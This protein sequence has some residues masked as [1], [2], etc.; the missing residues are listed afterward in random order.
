MSVITILD[1]EIE[2]DEEG[3][4]V[5]PDLWSEAIA[6]ALAKADG[7]GELTEKHWDAIR[8]IRQYWQENHMPPMV[9]SICENANL[10]LK[11]IYVLFPMGPHRGASKIAG[12]PGPD[13]CVQLGF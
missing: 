11:E 5:K 12:L 10:K 2:I 4:L 6:E 1:Q 13:N 9:R 8:Y 3:F 7:T